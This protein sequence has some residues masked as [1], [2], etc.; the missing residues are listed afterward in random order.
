MLYYDLAIIFE[1]KVKTRKSYKSC[2]QEGPFI[3]FDT[4]EL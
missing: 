3:K 2:L 1:V 4:P